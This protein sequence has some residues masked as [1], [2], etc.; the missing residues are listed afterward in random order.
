[1]TYVSRL[2][3]LD[4]DETK[5]PYHRKTNNEGGPGGPLNI[6]K[7]RDWEITWKNGQA[8]L[9][10]RPVKTGHPKK[11]SPETEGD[12]S[13]NRDGY[14]TGTLP[15][16][17]NAPIDKLQFKNND[18]RISE[19]NV[20]SY[21]SRLAVV[22]SQTLTF[23]QTLKIIK[24]LFPEI[25]MQFPNPPTYIWNPPKE[26]PSEKDE[27][28]KTEDTE[29]EDGS[30]TQLDPQKI[31]DKIKTKIP[32]LNWDLRMIDGIENTE[33]VF[34]D[35]ASA[36]FEIGLNANHLTITYTA[37]KKEEPIDKSDDAAFI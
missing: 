9:L 8:Q 18:R 17:P 22:L 34:A 7:A 27:K 24:K 19:E 28:D 10:H 31:K 12:N 14:N 11:D 20:M 35:G 32:D 2:K 25:K 30:V 26:G 36:L 29:P 16:D 13:F 15:S 6:E 5:S 33:M 4:K 1:M 3:Q 21:V 23:Q 37:P